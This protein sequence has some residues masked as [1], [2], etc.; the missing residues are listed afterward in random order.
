M[1]LIKRKTQ[2]IYEE[3]IQSPVF[4][5]EE[6]RDGIGTV[7]LFSDGSEVVVRPTKNY[8]AC[9]RLIDRIFTEKVYKKKRKPVIDK[10]NLIKHVA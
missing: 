1:Q 5:R 6:E 4:I 7:A 2:E 9:S 8:R 10:Q 3:R